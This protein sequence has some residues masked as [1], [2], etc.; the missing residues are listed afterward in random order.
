MIDFI[1]E[2]LY[3]ILELMPLPWRWEIAFFKA[4]A[5][6]YIAITIAF[7]AWVLFIR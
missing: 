7:L 1:G 2:C 3:Y 4:I 6:G 5:I